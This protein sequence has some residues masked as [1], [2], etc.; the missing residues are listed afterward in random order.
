[1]ESR[2]LLMLLWPILSSLLLGAFAFFGSKRLERFAGWIASGAIL[3]SLV[4]ALRIFSF[5]SAQ[6]QPILLSLGDWIHVGG[7]EVEALFR[8]DA[9]SSPLFVIVTGV[10]LLVH[11]YSIE[12]MSHDDSRTRY[13]CYLNLFCVFMLALLSG[14]TLP[15]LF[16]GWE[17]VGLM[18]FLLIGFWSQER[19]NAFAGRKAFIV[20]RIG[21]A[22]FLMGMFLLFKTFGTL[23]IDALAAHASLASLAGS[24]AVEWAM[25]FLFIGAVGKSAQFPLYLWLPDAMA[26]PTPVSA[27][28]HAATMVTAGVYLLCRMFFMLSLAPVAMEVVAW[29]GAITALY[30][31]SIALFQNDIKKVLAFSTV[32]QLGFM[33]LSVGSGAP[34]AA[35]HHLVTHAYFK[36]LLFLAAGSVIHALHGEQ[37]IQKMGGLKTY[38]VP[39]TMTFIFG[40][41]AIIGV[42]PFSGWFTKDAILHHVLEHG[43]S[44]LFAIG[45]VAA[46]L[47]AVYM[48]RLYYLVFL[49]SPRS[50]VKNLRDIHDSP[51]LMIGPMWV[52]AI[53]SLLGGI[54]WFHFEPMTAKHFVLERAHAEGVSEIHVA[55]LVTLLSLGSAL[56]AYFYLRAKKGVASEGAVLSWIS[57]E[58][59]LN[60]FAVRA[61]DGISC[62]VAKALDFV[63]RSV[64][65]RLVNLTAAFPVL[66]ARGLSRIQTGRTQAYSFVFAIGFVFLVVFL[67]GVGR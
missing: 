29:T 34:D 6:A 3:L 24:S 28:M 11:L 16:L 8:A 18:S 4:E 42:P 37:D 49:G 66:L 19:K 5:E 63:D 58:Y 59:G 54:A 60:D 1:M 51:A 40:Y 45:V 41:F 62:A 27:L 35:V 10:G 32:S 52:L 50:S 65:D 12:Y 7:L 2:I 23:R 38:L 13:F 48:T 33:V 20:N 25:L 55:L 61:A 26:G 14:G 64:V 47:T 67:L 30:S 44:G 31:A 22:G 17:G 53:L 43:H 57:R 9:L 15:I 39:T 46:M 21:D 56:G 36:A